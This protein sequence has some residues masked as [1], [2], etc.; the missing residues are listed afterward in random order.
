MATARDATEDVVEALHAGANDYVTK[1]LDFPVVLARV[2]TQLTLKRQK[3]EIRRLADDLEL[4]NTFIRGLFGRYVSEEVVTGLLAS[5]EGPQARGGA[6]SGDPA[7][8][9]PPRLHSPHRG[10]LPRSRCC[11]S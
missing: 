5:P 9:G 11:G 8:V 10:A 3:E 1:P 4:R 2:E 6:P 7:H